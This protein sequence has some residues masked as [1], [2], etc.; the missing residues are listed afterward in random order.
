MSEA[1]WHRWMLHLRFGEVP[2]HS[3]QWWQHLHS[4]FSISQ[5]NYLPETHK[6]TWLYKKADKTMSTCSITA[7]Q[8]VKTEGCLSCI[9]APH[10]LLGALLW[11]CGCKQSKSNLK[12]SSMSSLLPNT[13]DRCTKWVFIF[14]YVG[15]DTQWGIT[16]KD[17]HVKS[18]EET[19]NHDCCRRC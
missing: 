4:G 6:N 9:F 16:K 12:H 13:L 7:S 15:V 3:D 8:G 1:P 2:E 10:H 5:S 11:H 14:T 17:G 19:L 18:S